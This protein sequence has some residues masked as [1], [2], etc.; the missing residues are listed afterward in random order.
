MRAA[1]SMK[2]TPSSAHA[3]TLDRPAAEASNCV[4]ARRACASE[5]GLDY[6][7]A[8]SGGVDSSVAA[9]LLLERSGS[10]G[11]IT[12]C[13]CEWMGHA[14][15]AARA[16]GVP[17]EV[18]DCRLRFER[19]I[20]GPFAHA[21]AAGRTPNPCVFCNQL[22]KFG[23]LLDLARRRGA[24]RLAT[25]HYARVERG[26][27]GRYRLLRGLDHSKDQSY[28]LYRLGQEEL[29]AAA[30]PLGEMTKN[31]VRRHARSLGL[32]VT[33]K[34]ESQDICF[35]GGRR[36]VEVVEEHLRD[37]P[38]PGDIVHLDGRVLGRHAGVHRYT[39]GQRRGL[40]VS[41]NERLYIVCIDPDRNQVV[42][43]SAA[44][45]ERSNLLLTDTRWVRGS[46]PDNRSL[47]VR[48][49]YRHEGVPGRVENAD[50][51]TAVVRTETPVRGAA[52]GQ[53]AVLY[54]GE[55]LVGGG[56]VWEVW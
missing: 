25:G 56:T 39:V 31:E 5:T 13:L 27:D 14:V 43:G 49:R 15:E 1:C 21:F 9:A 30:F 40:R 6:L 45:L 53:A 28:F 36:Y 19:D 23:L 2:R 17:L 34:R 29:A 3:W 55:E 22:I 52:P 42:L 11:G 18:V 20:I 32:P 38:R 24:G 48:V 10:V 8:M 41:S 7:V 37:V 35:A 16:L 4:A 54:D 46:P 33:S 51:G 50:H 44:D 26:A 47:H 12:L